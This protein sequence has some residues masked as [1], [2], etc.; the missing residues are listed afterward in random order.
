MK[1]RRARAWSWL[2][3]ATARPSVSIVLLACLIGLVASAERFTWETHRSRVVSGMKQG[4]WARGAKTLDQELFVV[5]EGERFAVLDPN[6][7]SYDEA[8][9]AIARSPG[10]VG[11]LTLRLQSIVR[12]AFGRTSERWSLRI[13]QEEGAAF[14]ES[15]WRAARSAVI[16]FVY[17]PGALAVPE[18]ARLARED[19]V[20]TRP[21]WSGYILNALFL[22]AAAGFLYSLRWVRPALETQRDRGRARALRGGRCPNCGYSTVGLRAL[23]CP[24]CAADLR[25]KESDPG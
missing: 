14:T 11:V 6:N 24:E 19:F 15:D 23:I 4:S 18:F 5:R 22:L 20:V 21:L 7:D 1:E 2:N 3:E 9:R 8:T 13:K 12:G 16:T 25:M 17:G 10:Q